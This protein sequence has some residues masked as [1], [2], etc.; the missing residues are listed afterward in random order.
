MRGLGG[1]G[2]GVLALAALELATVGPAL[3]ETGWTGETV[4]TALAAVG[5]TSL[6]AMVVSTGSELDA[7]VFSLGTSRATNAM[8]ALT[9]PTRAIAPD[10]RRSR[11]ERLRAPGSRVA[12]LSVPGFGLPSGIITAPGVATEAAREPSQDAGLGCPTTEVF[13]A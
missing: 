8:A 12:G 13:G 1:G 6:A 3:V 5:G 10:S 2:A 4:T 7:D 11:D 9:S